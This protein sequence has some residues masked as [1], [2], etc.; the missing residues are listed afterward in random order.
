MIISYA[1]SPPYTF[2]PFCTYDLTYR[3]R[4]TLEA[5]GKQYTSEAVR[6]K[7][8]SRRWISTMNHGGCPSS[9][10]TTLAFR[11]DDNRLVLI[12]SAICR[13]ADHALVYGRKNDH[14]EDAAE[15]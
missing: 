2:N 10:G 1:F 3:L 9:K 11:L 12:G 14:Y 6:Q 5:E 4:V 15:R 7:S 8:R 13:D